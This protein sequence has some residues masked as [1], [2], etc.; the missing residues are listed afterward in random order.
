ME[1]FN[2]AID[3][4]ELA[5]ILA[6]LRTYQ[7]AGYGDPYNR[8]DDIHTIATDEDCVISLDA[9]GIDALCERLNSSQ[10]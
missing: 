3:R 5:T 4:Q 2:I 9:E 7:A 1:Q 10:S 8:P 6:A